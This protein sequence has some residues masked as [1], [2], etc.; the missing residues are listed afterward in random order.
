MDDK[1]LQAL[2]AIATKLGITPEYLFGVLVKQAPIS[3]TITL[4]LIAAWVYACV[5]LI[6]VTKR[7]TTKAPGEYYSEWD[8][9]LWLLVGAIAI[10]TALVCG[11]QLEIAV[12]ALV[13]PEYW[14][15]Q[16]ILN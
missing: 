12:S 3:G 6:R 5:A 9:V 14:A 4:L 10:G 13:N 11:L 7:K 15:L 8:P 2:T 1:T 16:Q